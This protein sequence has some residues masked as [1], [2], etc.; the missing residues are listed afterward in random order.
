MAWAM[1]FLQDVILDFRGVP[2]QNLLKVALL[3]S[4]SAVGREGVGEVT[5]GEDHVFGNLTS[6]I[7]SARGVFNIN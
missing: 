6:V 7:C 3:L 2:T 5:S 4:S 1:T